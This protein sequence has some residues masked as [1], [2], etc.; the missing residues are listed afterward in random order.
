MIEKT[1]RERRAIEAARANFAEALTELGLMAPFFNRTK[2]DI[3]RLI[4]A[5]VDGFQRS[6]VNQPRNTN[7]FDDEIPF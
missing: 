2:E 4:E 3:D 1:A 7:E 5:C 6:M